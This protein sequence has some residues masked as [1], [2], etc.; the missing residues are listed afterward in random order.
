MI[1]IPGCSERTNFKT[2]FCFIV[3]LISMKICSQSWSSECINYLIYS[4]ST[5]HVT[6]MYLIARVCMTD[7][8]LIAPT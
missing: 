8:V 4:F 5:A 2:Y 1:D 3:A 6:I 7:I